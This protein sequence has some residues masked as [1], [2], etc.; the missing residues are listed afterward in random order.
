MQLSDDRA[1]II[2]RLAAQPLENV[3]LLKHL[4]A[5]PD[6]TRA[7]AASDEGKTATLVLLDAAASP[8]DRATYPDAA[9]VAILVSE[10]EA[11]SGRLLREVPLA[12][13]A[14]FK[15]ARDPDRAALAGMIATTRRTAFHSFTAAAQYERDP[16]VRV[17]RQPRNDDFALLS[18][19]GHDR[20]VLA[21]M[22]ASGEAFVCTLDD[23]GTGE[24]AA[25]CCAFVNH[26]PVHEIGGVFTRPDRRGEGLA[27]RVVAT[28]LAVLRENGCLARYNVEETNPASLR[29]AARL[30][31][32]P[33]LTLTHHAAPKAAIVV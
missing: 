31:L 20:A 23:P 18:M 10:S 3:V 28:A 6:A 19:Q 26:G 12:G 8:Y 27:P 25:V 11:L 16:A 32:S 33:F 4:A 5:Y 1:A 21:R 22:L 7:L 29:L 24:T 13:G 9:V 15:L 30:G 14:V 2:S 17:T